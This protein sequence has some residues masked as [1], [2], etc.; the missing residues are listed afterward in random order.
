[1]GELQVDNLGAV[2]VPAAGL[3]QVDACIV[4]SYPR[5]VR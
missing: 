3:T 5:S 2:L 1:V 4:T